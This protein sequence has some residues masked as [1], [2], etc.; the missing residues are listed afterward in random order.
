MLSKA[1]HLDCALRVNSVK[2]LNY[3]LS[4]NSAKDLRVNSTTDLTFLRSIPWK[5]FS[6]IDLN[7]MLAY[8]AD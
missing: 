6:G 8:P 7:D 5:F 2:D 1:K 4:V 3:P